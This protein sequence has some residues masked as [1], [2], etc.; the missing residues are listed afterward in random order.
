MMTINSLCLESITDF[1]D[2]MIV[3]RK[4]YGF[5]APVMTLNI[6]RFPSFQSIA[7]LPLNLKNKFKKNLEI[8]LPKKEKYLTDGE[9]SHVVR[10]IDYLDVV[11]TPHRNTA[12]LPKIYNDF[13]YFY[14]QYDMRRNKN[15]TQ[16]FPSFVDWYKSIPY[17]E[18]DLK[19]TIDL[20]GDPATTDSFVNDD[21]LS[22]KD[23]VGG[24]NT[25]TDKLGA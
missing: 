22:I 24:W 9:I 6:L 19:G 14:E 12:E 4:K 21:K 2:D 18:N 23:G 20:E 3:L 15:F 7:I 11:K 10:L 13:R 8:W 17:N 1:M 25:T 5:R 16:T